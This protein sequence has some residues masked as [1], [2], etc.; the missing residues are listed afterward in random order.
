MRGGRSGHWYVVGA[1]WLWCVVVVG[2]WV[3]GDGGRLSTLVRGDYDDERR[4]SRRSAFGCH[5]AVHDVAPDSGVKKRN[6]S[7]GFVN[8]PGLVCMSP[9]VDGDEALRRPHSDHATCHRRVAL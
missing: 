6:G 9:V 7:E 1:R 3:F 2:P 5:V 8:S 4:I